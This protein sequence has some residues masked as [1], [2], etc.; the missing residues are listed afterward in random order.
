[1]A[2]F[3]GELN[4]SM[5]NFLLKK[6][7]ITLYTH[8]LLQLMSRCDQQNSLNHRKHKMRKR[9]K[10]SKLKCLSFDYLKFSVPFVLSVAIVVS[11]S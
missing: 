10:Q 6:L 8:P 4:W 1:M 9:L 3:D 7:L 2:A 5:Q 11:H